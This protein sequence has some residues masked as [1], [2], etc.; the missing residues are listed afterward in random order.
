L[1]ELQREFRSGR[2]EIIRYGGE[3]RLVEPG[4]PAVSRS[5]IVRTAQPTSQ[6]REPVELRR[7]RS[8]FTVELSPASKAAIMDEIFRVRR[9]GDLEAAG[10]LFAPKRPSFRSESV[11]IC[12][13]THAGDETRHS[14]YSV[15]L[16]DP[17]EVQASLPPELAHVMRVGCWH[18]HGVPGSDVPSDVD[19]RA[20]AGNL[21]AMALPFYTGI[22]A[23]PARDG[24]WMFPTLTPWCVRREGSPSKLICERA[25]FRW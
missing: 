1:E 3:I 21:D 2:H 11:L 24:G 10:F 17:Y 6:D 22:I 23:S 4:G 19:L 20:W 7:E 16:G 5:R 13:A 12:V 18:S 14:Q 9:H 8:P 25:R 15:A